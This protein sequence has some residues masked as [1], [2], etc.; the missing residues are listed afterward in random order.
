M[1]RARWRSTR[2][3]GDRRLIGAPGDQYVVG[4]GDQLDDVYVA[5]IPDL[6]AKFQIIGVAHAGSLAPRSRLS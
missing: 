5:V 4:Q 1:T 6:D 2:P 3:H